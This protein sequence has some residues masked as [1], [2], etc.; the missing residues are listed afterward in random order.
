MKSTATSLLAVLTTA[1]LVH[2][3]VFTPAVAAERVRNGNIENGNIVGSL[4]WILER[5]GITSPR[6]EG[7][8][9]ISKRDSEVSAPAAPKTGP[10]T[11][12]IGGSNVKP[13][14]LPFIARV[15]FATSK[16]PNVC[17]G[18]AISPLFIMTAGHCVLTEGVKNDPDSYVVAMGATEL[19]K[20]RAGDDFQVRGV[21]E[22]ILHPQY[23]ATTASND[24][25]LLKLKQPLKLGSNLGLAQL[26]TALAKPGQSLTASGWGIAAKGPNQG[27]T[28]ELMRANLIVGSTDKCEQASPG[29]DPN[30]TICTD[31]SANGKST[32]NGDSGGPIMFYDSKTNSYSV[33][34][35][36]S[37]KASTDPTIQP[38]CGGDLTMHFFIR[39]AAYLPW[40]SSVTG[41]STATLQ[42]KQAVPASPA[43]GSGKEAKGSA[44]DAKSNEMVNNAWGLSANESSGGMSAVSG[45]N[46]LSVGAAVVFGVAA[47]IAPY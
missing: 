22:T 23:D 21:A 15:T 38:V 33:A 47:A 24:I 16:G 32:C 11:H 39:V 30:L 3:S 20:G 31:D 4:N 27:V 9:V 37:F 8:I 19:T 34:G 2:N 18:V 46:A 25:A 35:L 13:S 26:T 41:V 10:Q 6:Q 29:L 17:T 14:E 1:C 5:A 42:S 43:P 7:M 12:I 28:A 36:T 45:Y 40:I 44:D